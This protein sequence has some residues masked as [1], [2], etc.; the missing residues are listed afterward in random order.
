M[1]A[2]PHS[3]AKGYTVM[4]SMF[5]MALVATMASIGLPG[6]QRLLD[7]QRATTRMHL[8]TTH[9]ALARSLAVAQR[10]PVSLCP[11]A[12]GSR[13]RTDSDWSRGWILFKDPGREGQPADA[14]SIFK[15]E[16]YPAAD[17]IDARA[18]HGRPVVRFL[19]SGLSSGTNITISLCANA[20]R[21]ADVVVNNT[22]RARTVRHSA[23]ISCQTR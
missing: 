23:P 2:A 5:V 4:Q 17:G 8:L 20:Q 18:T 3:N 19:P 21:L 9:L 12:D 7:W 15:V 14:S 1:Q 6:F 16:H 13:C 22:G 11:S 10:M